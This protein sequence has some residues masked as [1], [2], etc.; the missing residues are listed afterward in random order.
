MSEYFDALAG[1]NVSIF[2][3]EKCDP[4]ATHYAIRFDFLPYGMREEK[5]LADGTKIYREGGEIFIEDTDGRRLA[6]CGTHCL[7]A[8][9]YFWICRPAGEAKDPCDEEFMEEISS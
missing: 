7:P 5:E 1:S 4:F 3:C 8:G 2:E 6:L 9:R